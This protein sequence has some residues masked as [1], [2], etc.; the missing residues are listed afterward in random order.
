MTEELFIQPHPSAIVDAMA[1]GQRLHV[2]AFACIGAGAELGDDVDIA[3]QVLV[4]GSVRM[5]NRVAVRCGAKLLGRLVIEDDVTIDANAVFAAHE[6]AVD[7]G[8][9]TTVRRGARIGANAT[10]L[11]GLTIGESA[12]VNAG[13]VVTQDVPAFAIVGGNPSQI[14][15]YV[16]ALDAGWA[17]PMDRPR[18]RTR[19]RVKDAN[20]VPIPQMADMR[21]V[22]TFAELDKQLPFVATRFFVVTDV[23]GREVRGEHAHKTLHEFLVCLKGSLSV[24]LDDGTVREEVRL[25]APT[26]GLH[27]PPQVWRVVYKYTPDAL[28]LSLCSHGY[29]PHDYIR[30]YPSFLSYVNAQ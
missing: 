11:A 18:D 2:G 21:G 20:L 30:D 27:V 24:M 25:D 9:A 22:T 6:P 19:L 12:R 10:V 3:E 4:S 13:A 16:N 17:V 29:D 23:P 8:A 15:G 1:F 7:G 5:G 14:V 26:L 28:L